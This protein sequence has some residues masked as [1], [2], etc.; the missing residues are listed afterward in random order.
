MYLLVI[1]VLLRSVEGGEN[2]LDVKL[3][4]AETPASP[5]FM[6]LGIEPKTVERPTSPK[7]LAIS[8]IPSGARENFVPMAIEFA[9]YWLKSHPG[10]RADTYY[11]PNHIQSVKQTFTISIATAKQDSPLI[12][13]NLGLGVKF[14]PVPGKTSIKTDSLRTEVRKSSMRR[15]MLRRVSQIKANG[16]FEFSSKARK[17]LQGWID[18]HQQDT[19]KVELTGLSAKDMGEFLEHTKEY[20]TGLI[21]SKQDNNTPKRIKGIKKELMVLANSPDS[22]AILLGE[23]KRVGVKMEMAGA[24]VVGFTQNT[25]AKRDLIRFGAWTTLS[26]TPHD[27]T[28]EWLATARYMRDSEIDRHVFD[29]GGRI[30]AQSGPIA[31]S[32]EVLWRF[33]IGCDKDRLRVAGVFEFA[34]SKDLFLIAVVGKDFDGGPNRKNIISAVG[35][36]IGL[37]KERSVQVGSQM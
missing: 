36:N 37:S 17:R 13:T 11:N 9:P 31:V 4:D 18:L 12:G 10:L 25:F 21:S 33:R 2:T 24:I 19:T 22:A 8:I 35:L 7:D 14:Q 30:I 29:V 5:G 23:S 16:F 34:I 20:I 15:G 6:L 3:S 32:G 1:F 26:Y 27:S 28:P